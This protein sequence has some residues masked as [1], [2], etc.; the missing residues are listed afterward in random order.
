MLGSE[1][2]KTFRASTPYVSSAPFPSHLSHAHLDISF[3]MHFP[4]L[5]LRHGHTG[6]RTHGLEGRYQRLGRT[7]HRWQR[8]DPF[9]RCYS[10]FRLWPRTC[11][12]GYV[13][14]RHCAVVVDYVVPM[15]YFLGIHG[16]IFT[17]KI[18]FRNA[19]S[20]SGACRINTLTCFLDTILVYLPNANLVRRRAVS[21]P[22]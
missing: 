8:Y 12:L 13:R 17:M 3:I 5:I 4:W 10:C 16:P 15:Y 2:W 9:E 21:L 22:A 6:Q 7:I 11:D 20:V 1:P 18:R 19:R 14:C